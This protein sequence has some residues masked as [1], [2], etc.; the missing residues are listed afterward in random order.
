MWAKISAS[1]CIYICMCATSAT[2][3]NATDSLLTPHK[4]MRTTGPPKVSVKD[5]YSARCQTVQKVRQIELARKRKQRQREKATPVMPPPAS[6]ANPAALRRSRQRQ[7]MAASRREELRP[8]RSARLQALRERAR[9]RRQRETET[10]RYYCMATT[11]I[12]LW[13]R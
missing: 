2:L 6:V 12:I 9:E 3:R 10:Q 7:R 13:L 1:V 8:Q 5:Y 11:Q 4:C